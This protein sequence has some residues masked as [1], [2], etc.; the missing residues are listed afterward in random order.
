MKFTPEE[1]IEQWGAASKK[2][3]SD[4]LDIY[5]EDLAEVFNEFDEK[6]KKVLEIGIQRG[7]NVCFL[8]DV[9]PAGSTVVG[10]DI[11]KP[12]QEIPDSIQFIQGSSLDKKIISEVS[13]SGPFDLIIEDASHIQNHVCRNID[14]FAPM[15]KI[16]GTMI[17]EDTQY[18]LLPG[19]GRGLFGRKNVLNHYI[20]N[21]YKNLT[22]Q[23]DPDL[24]LTARFQPYS[25]ILQRVGPR[26]IFRLD[27]SAGNQEEM[28]KPHQFELFKK[29]LYL[30][31]EQRKPYIV[32]LLVSLLLKL[33]N[34]LR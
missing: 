30:K 15:L 7:G 25:I 18:A 6:P 22:F 13:K 29:I 20:K 8:I 5:F 23:N 16:N 12:I 34:Y 32:F 3:G 26:D 24:I 11:H 10:I 4:K 28:L 17:I 31:F 14:N 27:S 2:L 21:Y 33:R 1:L 19:W 9:L